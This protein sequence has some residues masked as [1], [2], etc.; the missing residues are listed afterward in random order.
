MNSSSWISSV[1]YKKVGDESYIAIFLRDRPEALLYGG[2]ESP[3]PSWL[4][5]LVQAGT[6]GKSIGHAYHKLLRGK[7]P[8]QTIK[9]EK[10]VKELKEMMS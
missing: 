8:C 2:P 6:G 4:P 5:G 7:F 3:V 9:G 1:V 10:E